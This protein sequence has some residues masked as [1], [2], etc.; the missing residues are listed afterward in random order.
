MPDKIE[1]SH[2]T[3]WL[4]SIHIHKPLL[5]RNLVSLIYPFLFIMTAITAHTIAVAIAAQELD[6]L[7]DLLH[8]LLRT[9]F[10]GLNDPDYNYVIRSAPL[11]EPGQ[12]YLHWYLSIIPRLTY[13]A[14]FELGT[15]M[16][17]NPVKPEEAAAF[18]RDEKDRIEE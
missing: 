16:F 5:K 3:R 9:L 8:Q 17:I 2:P 18:L 4:P 10:H 7:S 14:G 13:A 11:N 15:G 12:D 6:A 1:G